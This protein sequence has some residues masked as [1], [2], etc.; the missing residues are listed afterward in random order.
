MADAP[1]LAPILHDQ[2][3]VNDVL[4]FQPYVEAL[5]GI[6]V[7]PRTGS[8]LT[9]GIYGGWGSG[10]TSLMRMIQAKVD[11][12]GHNYRSVWFNAWQYNHED[13]LWRALL[14]TLVDELEQLLSKSQDQEPPES[15]ATPGVPSS[16]ELVLL[17]RE[18]LYRDTAWTE[19]GERHVHWAEAAAAGAR[20]ALDVALSGPWQTAFDVAATATNKKSI[21]KG[22]TLATLGKLIASFRADEQ[23]HYQA[24]L[25]SL[26]QFQANFAELIK[27]LLADDAGKLVVFVDDLDRCT[28]ENAIRV[29]EALKLFL[30]V[31]GCIF[32]LG[33]D[34]EAIAAA[35][36]TRYRGEVKANEYLE[37]II[38]L[39]F[40][41]PLIADKPMQRYV[42]ALT[43]KNLDGPCAEVFVLGLADNP[44]PRKVK[45]TLN[46]F[47]LMS[48]LVDKRPELKKTL[49]SV[50]L[51]KL[52]AIQQAYPDLYA[53]VLKRPGA[54]IQL[55]DFFRAGREADRR[56]DEA[57]PLP[58]ALKPFGTRDSLRRL[59]CL[60]EDAVAR[61]GSLTLE[62][63][64]E[65]ITLT[66][67]AAPEA[68][69]VSVTR[70]AFEPEMVPVPAGP[71]MMGTSKAQVDAML[72]RFEWA[73]VGQ[74]KGWFNEEQ[75]EHEVT[76]PAFEIGRYPITNVQY[77]EFVRAMHHDVPR[78]WPE[79]RV[80]DEL[81]G[82]P[83]INVTWRDAMAYAAWLSEK[84]G[85]PYRLPSEAEWE[86]AARG[87]DG[88]LWPWG[89]D[90]DPERANCRPAGPGAT[91]LV[92]QYS[93]RGD[94]P[95][96]AADMAGNVWEW[97]LTKWR[98]TNAT[99]PDDDPAGDALRVLRGGSWVND[100]PGIVRCACRH[101]GS[102]G[103]RNALGG[104]RVARS[105]LR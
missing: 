65:F 31:P 17:L 9:L 83:V 97:C 100:N 36:Q 4:D 47:L 46:T 64:K 39:P 21:G 58:D 95:C 69:A 72:R 7:D 82:H 60:Q 5:A 50:R 85:R 48:R 55:E 43:Q 45:R 28:A 91:T 61:F 66:R 98:E 29:L 93:P 56:I 37:K 40:Y 94:S 74:E 32:V 18:A 71:F 51:A 90:W 24:E 11:Q 81:A 16:K 73:K 12:E 104:F 105:S 53:E 92:G 54:L 88:R 77:A 3:A 80:P 68:P 41:L 52:V 25:R 103:L 22:E 13:A 57:V 102:P 38:Q 2:P 87:D 86:K 101:G 20:L 99:P 14:L 70:G 1:T 84:T 10:K 78:H 34:P 96:G 26:E 89:N 23:S 15:P 33:L 35:V 6:I 79:G 42:E 59:F 49:T 27:R 63:L 19:R 8:P 75:P 62:E 30:D 44:T 76:L 67:Q